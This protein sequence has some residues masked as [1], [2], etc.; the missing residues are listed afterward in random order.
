[1]R[2]ENQSQRR[3][4]EWPKLETNDTV[5]F[6]HG[7]LLAS[8]R[9]FHEIDPFNS[10]NGAVKSQKCFSSRSMRLI[11]TQNQAVANIGQLQTA[12]RDGKPF[13]RNELCL[14]LPSPSQGHDK[15]TVQRECFKQNI[16]G[17]PLALVWVEAVGK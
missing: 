17:E 12:E 1:M 7:C 15:G 16:R 5:A 10:L 14:A 3:D 6:N 13:A 9:L 11:D 8:F 4:F 2:F